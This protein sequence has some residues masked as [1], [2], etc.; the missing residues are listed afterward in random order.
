MEDGRTP[1]SILYGKLVSGAQPTNS[2]LQGHL[3]QRSENLWHSTTRSRVG[4]VRSHNL[5]N[6]GQER[7]QINRKEERKAMGIEDEREYYPPHYHHPYR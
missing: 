3:Q 7:H 4:D 6:K 2:A 5:V 1:K